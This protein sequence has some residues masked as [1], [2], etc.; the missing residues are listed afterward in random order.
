[1]KEQAIDLT[2]ILIFGGR[3]VHDDGRL[4]YFKI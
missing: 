2:E 4:H 3:N 1:V